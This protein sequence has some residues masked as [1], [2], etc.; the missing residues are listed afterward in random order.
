MKD[1]PK[2]TVFVGSM[3]S[4]KTSKLIS[5]LERYKYQ[6]KRISAFKPK[7]D[8]RYSISEIVTHS[9]M[10]MPALCISSGAELFEELKKFDEVPHV[11]AVDEAFMI[12]GITD[13]LVYLYKL[14]FDIVVSSL[15]MS[16]TA[17]PFKEIEKMLP[18]ATHIEKCSAV[19]AV[20]GRDAHY[21]Y[22][23][24]SSDEE[25]E[26]GGTELYEPRCAICHPSIMNQDIVIEKLRTE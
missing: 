2:L 24:S 21:T 18:W 1:C 22:K 5:H 4:G 14:G 9:G 12:D 10:K 20:C 19:C 7:I 11:I 8:A 26:V 3:F 15:E 17:K 13:S 6:H 16:A 23:K 25:I